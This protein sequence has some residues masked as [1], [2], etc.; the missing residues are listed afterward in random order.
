MLRQ[1][2]HYK[3]RPTRS[4][5]FFNQP[6]KTNQ[7]K[8]TTLQAPINIIVRLVFG[9]KALTIQFTA[10]IRSFCLANTT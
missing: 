8:I 9:D 4:I 1:I 6:N 3:I 2:T 7:E 10:M 5:N